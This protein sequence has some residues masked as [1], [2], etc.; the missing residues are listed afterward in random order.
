MK[1]KLLV[2]FLLCL[3]V[4]LVGFTKPNPMV[5]TW[6]L[7]IK[8]QYKKKVGNQVSAKMVFKDNGTFSAN[9]HSPQG[10]STAAGEYKV[11]GKSLTLVT[12]EMNGKKGAVTENATLSND[13][14][15]F[16]MPQ[17]GGI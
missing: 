14:K 11:S 12:K 17:F 1:T 8:E 5:G 13:M 3:S 16:D 2:L 10:N 7:Q 9:I 4:F 6:V 15:S